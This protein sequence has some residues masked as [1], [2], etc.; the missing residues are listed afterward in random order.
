MTYKL[1]RNLSWRYVRDFYDKDKHQGISLAPKL[2]DPH[3]EKCGYSDMKVKYAAQIFSHTVAAG[4]YT[5]ILINSLIHLTAAAC[6]ITRKVAVPCQ[7]HHVI[8][9]F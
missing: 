1:V 2:T 3:I 4:V 9:H 8:M 5:Q 6:I 7:Q